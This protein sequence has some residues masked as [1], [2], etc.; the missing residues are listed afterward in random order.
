MQGHRA[1][2]SV[3]VGHLNDVQLDNQDL[4]AKFSSMEENYL[5]IS[6]TL[7]NEQ[8]RHVYARI[9][10]FYELATASGLFEPWILIPKQWRIVFD[11]LSLTYS[12]RRKRPSKLYMHFFFRELQLR[13]VF[14]SQ[15]RVNA[16]R[17]PGGKH[18]GIFIGLSR[19]SI[20]LT[21]RNQEFLVS[22]R[23]SIIWWNAPRQSY[24]NDSRQTRV[25]RAH[26]LHELWFKNMLGH[27]TV[28]SRN[29]LTPK[30]K[31]WCRPPV[32]YYNAWTSLGVRTGKVIPEVGA[33]NLS[34]GGVFWLCGM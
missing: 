34:T 11:C 14:T 27:D 13:S 32:S 17:P 25:S 2:R 4:K 8:V 26:F 33:L 9:P 23:I 16:S 19:V 15:L 31:V 22:G 3:L 7:D 30:S 20:K 18:A 28:V 24:A 10:F 29:N 12:H 1:Y 21:R 5:R 6:L